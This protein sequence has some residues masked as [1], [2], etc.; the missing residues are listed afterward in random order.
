[1]EYNNIINLNREHNNSLVSNLMSVS[2]PYNNV[3]THLNFASIR[4]RG[5]EDVG[6]ADNCIRFVKND[7]SSTGSINKLYELEKNYVRSISNDSIEELNTIFMCQGDKY[8][9]SK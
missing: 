4:R 9:N 3:L 2:N 6:A 7:G 8:E 1:M 5:L